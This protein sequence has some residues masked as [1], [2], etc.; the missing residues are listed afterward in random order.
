MS[1]WHFNPHLRKLKARVNGGRGEIQ[2]E[3]KGQNF[4]IELNKLMI[5]ERDKS[6]G[7]R[8]GGRK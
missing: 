4:A 8:L 1:V 5:R 3:I 2:G 6:R 7:K